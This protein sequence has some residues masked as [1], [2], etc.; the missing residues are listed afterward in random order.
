M[1]NWISW[2][3]LWLCIYLFY[4][5]KSITFKK[6]KSPF[7]N[8][9][10]KFQFYPFTISI[11]TILR[12]VSSS[13]FFEICRLLENN[14]RKKQKQMACKVTS[15]LLIVSFTLT[16]SIRQSCSGEY[17]KGGTLFFLVYIIPIFSHLITLDF[18]SSA[19]NVNFIGFFLEG[20]WW[21]TEG[22]GW[23]ELWRSSGWR[24]LDEKKY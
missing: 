7:E 6:K 4:I 20:F 9:N 5:Y 15:T 11:N 21:R 14:K 8:L 24:L 22:W 19:E 12:R 1:L 18:W 16:N 13:R 3:P 17:C 2:D 10:T 23:R